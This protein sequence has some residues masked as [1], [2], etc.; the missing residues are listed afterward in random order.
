MKGIESTSWS[1]ITILLL[2]HKSEQNPCGT[3]PNTFL[4]LHAVTASLRVFE[5]MLA[6]DSLIVLHLQN[7]NRAFGTSCGTGKSY[8]DLKTLL[9]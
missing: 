9:L 3:I 8:S 5:R 2:G 1:E 4:N 7:H 6:W